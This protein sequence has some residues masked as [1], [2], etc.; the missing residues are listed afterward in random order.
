MPL[1][2]ASFRGKPGFQAMTRSLFPLLALAASLSAQQ[3]IRQAA[4]ARLWLKVPA[5]QPPCATSGSLTAAPTPAAWEKDPA[6]RERHTDI[7]FPIRW[8]SWSELTISFTPAQ[9]GTVELVLNGPWA[10]EKNGM[11]PRQEILWD[12]LSAEGTTLH[13]GGFEDTAENHPA[14]WKS[15]WAPYPA[16]DAWPLAHAEAMQENAWRPPG[17]TAR[18]PRPSSS[19]PAKRSPS[20]ST[21]KPPPRPTS[22]RP[23][24]SAATP[25]HTA[26]SPASNA[27]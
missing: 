4:E 2:T 9:D 18:S 10:P 22:S 19:K 12:D 3:P 17:T 15:P 20:S 23:N 27:A 16:A 13:N 26:P 21:R 8:W 11:M 25:R 5:G 14:S 24:A 1:A 7:V 6:V